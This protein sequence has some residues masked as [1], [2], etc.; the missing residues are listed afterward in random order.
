MA[1]IKELLEKKAKG[2][3]TD[4]ELK[5]LQE[6]QAEAQEVNET[7][8]GEDEN[9]QE[10]EEA[11]SKMADKLAE[12]AMGRLEAGLQKVIKSMEE[13]KDT[14][15]IV[16]HESKFIVD[17]KLGRKTVEELSEIKV[18][19]PG[20]EDKKVKEVSM[21]TMHFLNALF[22]GDKEKLQVL[23]EGTGGLGGFLV[24]EEFANMIVEDI[25]DQVVMRQLADVL[26]TTS[27]TLHLPNLAR[28]PKANWRGEAAAKSTS[29]VEWGENVFTPYSLASI[30]TLSNELVA[31]A[32]LGVN[33]SIVNYVSQVIVRALAETEDKAF[34]VGSGSGQPT[35]I[36]TYT[37][38]IVA[39]SNN[40]ASRADA[41]K[42]AFIRTPQGYRGRG[43][44]VMNSAT[45][46]K[47]YTLKDSQGNYLVNRLSDNP[48]A[49]LAGRPVYEQNDLAGGKAFFGD[50][51]YYKIV[52]R[53]GI[54]VRVSDE[55]TVGGS[56]GFEKNL[57]HVRVEKRVD[58]EL[59]LTEP[60]TE[61]T[62]LGTP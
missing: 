41:I 51:S 24:P 1:R 28:R 59:T 34:F 37:F 3:I 46:E 56:S 33:G 52:D 22:T 57:T 27:D 42:Q 11:I 14:S 2:E 40:D 31:D 29:T 38:R 30:V 44:W 62:G 15:V 45:L 25:R 39:A 50:F 16:S 8:T 23:V 18:A 55:A 6:L 20:R 4:V 7:T 48:F 17:P 58:G 9:A 35:G 43:A 61:V 13:K 5:E 21:K 19:I 54:S 12:S 26:T 47:V 36:E 49:T 10:E 60:I 32:S 53:E